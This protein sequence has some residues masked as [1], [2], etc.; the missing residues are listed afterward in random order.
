M[1]AKDVIFGDDARSKMVEGVNVLANA[2]KVTLGRNVVLEHSFGAPTITKDGVS[3]AKEIELKDKLMNMGA[4]MV[5]EVASKTSDLAGDG[6]TTATVLAQSIVRE[7]AHMENLFWSEHDGLYAD[8]AT[9]NCTV[10][11]YL[12]QNAN[13]HSCEAMIT[14]FEATLDKKYINRAYTIA[15]NITLRQAALSNT[16]GNWIWEHYHSDWSLI[17][18][19]TTL[20]LS[21]GAYDRMVETITLIRKHGTHIKDDT[22][23][24][25]PRAIEL[26]E[27]AI[28][29][30][31][32]TE[33]GGMYYGLSPEFSVCDSDKYFWDPHNPQNNKFYSLIVTANHA[34]AIEGYIG[35]D[36]QDLENESIFYRIKFY[37]PNITAN[38]QTLEANHLEEI[39]IG[40]YWNFLSGITDSVV[41]AYTHFE[42]KKIHPQQ[43]SHPILSSPATQTNEVIDSQKMCLLIRDD[44]LNNVLHDFEKIAPYYQSNPKH[45]SQ[46]EIAQNIVDFFSA[47]FDYSDDESKNMSLYELARVNIDYVKSYFNTIIACKDFLSGDQLFE[48]LNFKDINMKNQLHQQP[49]IKCYKKTTSFMAKYVLNTLVILIVLSNN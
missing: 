24:L 8:E 47:K 38:T 35:I 3:V 2:V 13:I 9:V 26:F 10:S 28:N 12:G 4:Q 36:N 33:F 20:G 7:V 48:L 18:I 44:F 17:G 11:S 46:K 5:K 41:C 6:T 31:W 1:A 34:M 23:W 27:V 25:L 29:L 30:A 21:T 45:L 15:K 14:A 42:N 32:D 49:C 40:I 22:N 16:P 39:A 37:D 43:N 19:T